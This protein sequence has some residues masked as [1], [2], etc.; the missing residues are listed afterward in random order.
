L[1]RAKN[2]IVNTSLALAGAMLTLLTLEIT[3]RCLPVD[4]HAPI[5]PPTLDDP[6]QRYV[7]DAPLVTSMDWDMQFVVR[8]RTNAQGWI[9]DYDYD[10]AASTPLLAVV[11]DSYIEGWGVPFPQSAAGR[12]QAAFGSRA[13]VYAFAQAGAPLSQYVA[14]ARHACALY[15]P[16]RM[17]VSIVY[18][19]F[20]ES[21][22][23][24]RA[25]D[26]FFHLRE[27]SDGHFD[28]ELSPY[29]APSLVQ[30]IA[31]HSALGV[32]LLRN[33]GLGRWV[34]SLG[35]D[36]F[37]VR[38][39]TAIV[40]AGARQARVRDG[41][42]AIDWFLDA[43]TEAACLPAERILLVVDAQRAAIYRPDAAAGREQNSYFG[44]MRSAL[45]PAASAKGYGVLDLDPVFRRAY[46]VDHERFEFPIDRHW[47]AHGHAVVAAAINERLANWPR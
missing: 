18:N 32:Y 30:T 41:L 34:E 11:G 24:R 4:W 26:G 36:R 23:A 8:E 37:R 7:P 21:L 5:R 9:A 28:L 1:G 22:Y 6:I 13:R 47:N 31:R 45:I 2:V 40:P 3:L 15:H 29:V 12:L 46:A 33:A 17:V 25:Y 27:H 38:P 44:V 35:M 20:D 10:A 16:E 43:L 39:T 14:Y 42:R 19:D